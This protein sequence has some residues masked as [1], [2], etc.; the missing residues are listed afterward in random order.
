MGLEQSSTLLVYS[1]TRIALIMNRQT[2]QGV[3]CNAVICT[4]NGQFEILV[5]FTPF[6]AIFV[7]A[8]VE[9]C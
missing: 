1:G 4:Y 7:V 2:L 5:L 3:S 9:N 6:V 8:W